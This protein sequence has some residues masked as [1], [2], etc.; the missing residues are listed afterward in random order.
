MNVDI[1]CC[2]CSKLL[3]DSTSRKKRKKLHSDTCSQSKQILEELLAAR[4]ATLSDFQETRDLDAY[5]CYLCNGKAVS[6]KNLQQR[7]NEVKIELLDK[8][9]QLKKVTVRKRLCV[10]IENSTDKCARL[11]SQCTQTLVP[12]TE[13]SQ[14]SNHQLVMG[15]DTTSSSTNSVSSAVD[16]QIPS[17]HVEC[18]RP[19][20]SAAIK[21][22]KSPALSVCIHACKYMCVLCT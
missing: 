5:L 19:L 8:L 13:T 20:Q 12:E 15:P 14:T 17:Q 3:S 22:T 18:D 11:D 1:K 9:Q 7:I 10:N 4:N 21:P 16:S 6:F 2:L